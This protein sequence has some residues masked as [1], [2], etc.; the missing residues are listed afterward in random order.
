MNG[1]IKYLNS[2]GFSDSTIQQHIRF[3][4]FF[5]DWLSEKSID[6]IQCKYPEMVMFI[7]DALRFLYFRQN[8]R[9]S[10]NRMMVAISYYYDFLISN[11]SNLVNPAKNIRIKNPHKQI[12]HDLL[13]LEELME[14]YIFI[15]PK[16]PRNIRNKVMLGLFVFQGLST[17]ELHRLSLSDLKLRKGTIFIKGD[18]GSVWKKGSTAREL[19][20]EA[21]QI[22]DLLEYIEKIRLK[23]LSK[24]YDNLPGR[25]PDERNRTRRTDQ[26]LLS[27]SGSP[28]LK[29]SLIHMF[30]ELRKLNPKVK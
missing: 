26:L 18:K 21:L 9:S 6:S 16:D 11:N 1:F 8:T 2:I 12:V 5:N 29:N 22:I 10:L 15:N 4:E 24:S 27:I 13:N 3:V 14:L 7:D 17:R 19:A 23:I 20:L 30:I 25:K 28:H